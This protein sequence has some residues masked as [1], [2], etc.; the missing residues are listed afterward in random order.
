MAGRKPKQTHYTNRD[1]QNLKREDLEVIRQILARRK[2]ARMRTLEH[3]KSSITGQNYAYGAYD[4]VRHRL[5]MDEKKRFSIRLEY[6]GERGE[7]QDEIF[8]LQWFLNQPTSTV[9]G[10][11]AIEEARVN[12]LTKAGLSEK[13]ARSKDLYSFF[14]SSTFSKLQAKMLKYQEQLYESMNDVAEAGYSMTD[15]EEAID[16]WLSTSEELT[17][18]DLK[19][20]GRKVVAKK[21]A[22]NKASKAKNRRKG[23]NTSKGGKRRSKRK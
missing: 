6:K 17:L 14:N 11:R 1:L 10:M 23:T 2:N 21:K 8:Q 9:S 7:L 15:L 4:T 18:K 3:S 13:V 12:Q 22:Q 5:H 19:Q 16:D 20:L